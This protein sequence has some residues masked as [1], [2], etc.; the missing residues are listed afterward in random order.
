MEKN[1]MKIS[2]MLFL[3]VA[4]CLVSSSLSQAAQLIL[5]A[6]TP[7]QPNVNDASLDVVYNQANQ[8]F[9]VTNYTG[10]GSQLFI[11]G[12]SVPAFYEYNSALTATINAAG[13]ITGG[14]FDLYGDMDS[15][16]GDNV[17]LAGTIKT[18]AS[19]TAW[20]YFNNGSVD[21]FSFLFTVTS[22]S[23]PTFASYFGGVGATDGIQLY[24]NFSDNSGHDTP[25]TGTWGSSFSNVKASGS[26][27]GPG[28]GLGTDDIYLVPE[29]SPMAL[30][31]VGAVLYSLINRRKAILRATTATAKK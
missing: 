18:G 4:V 29:P 10:G 26:N 23:D 20:G 14:T 6:P 17:L 1:N 27:S 3:A 8:T 28:S 11:G 22:A 19:G 16:T 24:A 13:T 15:G 12:S 9:G 5:P 31:P 30:I 25:F 7:N 21:Q 2:K